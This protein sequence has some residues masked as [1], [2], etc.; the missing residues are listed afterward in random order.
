MSKTAS[1]I[2]TVG[3]E[4]RKTLPGPAGSPFVRQEM[5][6]DGRVW[7]GMVTTEPG[8]ASPWHHHGEHE[9]YVYILEGEAT[10]EFGAGGSQH[11]HATAD[12]SLHIVPPG[13]PHREINTGSTANRML[14][15]RIGAGPAVVP[16]DG[17]P[18]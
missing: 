12:G 6:G 11:L 4:E 18:E 9:T 17:P 2:R 8:G 1:P 7:V 3:P 15:V 16:L 14:V 5:F 13:V 10:V